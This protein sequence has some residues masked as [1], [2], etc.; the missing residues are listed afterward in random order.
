MD[1]VIV[2]ASTTSTRRRESEYLG[3]LYRLCEPQD[4]VSYG[5]KFL[6]V[7]DARLVDGSA[8]HT[9]YR[10]AG[11]IGLST[12]AL[13]YVRRPLLAGRLV[14]HDFPTEG[15]TTASGTPCGM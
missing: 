13:S 14:A 4:I 5:Q 10:T 6:Q 3:R 11:H 2:L 7:R 9:Q 8:H 15:V 12:R 1:S